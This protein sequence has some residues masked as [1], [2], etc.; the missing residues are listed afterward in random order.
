MSALRGIAVITGAAGVSM[1]AGIVSGTNAGHN[2]NISHSREAEHKFLKNGNGDS[3]ADFITDKKQILTIT[4]VP[5]H[6]TTLA[7]SQT[8]N[9][10]YRLAAGTKITVADS[11]GGVID[12]DYLLMSSK[13]TRPNDD[14]NVIELEM[15]KWDDNDLTT[16]PS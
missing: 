9:D 10:A 6:A 1:T 16:T 2:Q 8:S 7:T 5:Y 13:E 14:H 15:Q 11:Q 12:G 4:V 3:V